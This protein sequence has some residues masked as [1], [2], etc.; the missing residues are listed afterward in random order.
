[1]P[2]QW[3]TFRVPLWH[4]VFQ[5][6]T[7]ICFQLEQ[8]LSLQVWLLASTRT[9]AHLDMD[10]MHQ[11]GDEFSAWHWN[12]SATLNQIIFLKLFWKLF[13]ERL[14]KWMTFLSSTD[15]WTGAW[16]PQFL[17]KSLSFGLLTQW[18][19]E[20]L[21]DLLEWEML[22]MLQLA[23]DQVGILL[24]QVQIQQKWLL[25]QLELS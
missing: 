5:F 13:G 7:K 10:M 17:L 18:M 25:V 1:M 8:P 9:R 20:R 16:L 24:H 2:K 4:T 14:S 15:P 3:P 21:F 22:S 6:W 19:N 23:L 11:F 12:R